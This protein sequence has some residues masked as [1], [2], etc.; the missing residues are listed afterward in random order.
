MKVSATREE[1]L[2]ILYKCVVDGLPFFPAYGLALDYYEPDYDA[3]KTSWQERNTGESVCREDIWVEIVRNG[4]TL[5]FDDLEEGAS[6]QLNLDTIDKNWDSIADHAPYSFAA[7][8]ADDY[9]ANNSC[10]VFQCL[11]FGEV[12]YA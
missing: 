6:F 12:R 2:D 4:G 7:L 10:N 8:V 1:K 3:A 9:D 5:I 11:L